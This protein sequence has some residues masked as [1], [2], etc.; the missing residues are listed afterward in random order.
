MHPI[1]DKARVALN[2]VLT[3]LVP[4]HADKTTGLE[5][6]PGE[7]IKRCIEMVKAEASEAA[8][9]IAECAPQGRPMLAQAQMKLG[10]L[11]SLK[12]LDTVVSDVCG[13]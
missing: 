3:A 8:S 13:G 6:D 10:H 4:Q 2:D 12:M 1:R 7:R 5:D 11:E 9:L